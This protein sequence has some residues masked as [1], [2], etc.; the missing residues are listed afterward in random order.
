MKRKILVILSMVLAFAVANVYAAGKTH[1]SFEGGMKELKLDGDNNVSM[2][3]GN[4]AITSDM[5]EFKGFSIGA[6]GKA[7]YFKGIEDFDGAYDVDFTNYSFGIGPVIAK[8]VD[9]FRAELG[10]LVTYD[11]VDIEFTNSKN[12]FGIEPF[13]YAGVRVGES[14]RVGIK[15]A[16]TYMFDNTFESATQILGVIS[17]KF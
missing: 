16:Y 5:Y 15:G 17:V 11:Y 14:V 12:L 8:D 10:V 7:G 3:G 9:R 6:N 13:V 4:V 1:V 2:Y